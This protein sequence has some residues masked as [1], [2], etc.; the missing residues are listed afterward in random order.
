MAIARA[1]E[2]Y[3][4]DLVQNLSEFMTLCSPFSRKSGKSCSL[5]VQNLFG[6]DV[7]SD[8]LSKVTTLLSV[9][10]QILSEL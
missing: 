7:E 3:L 4:I 6:P 5:G 1:R 2:A 10:G 9:W 8:L